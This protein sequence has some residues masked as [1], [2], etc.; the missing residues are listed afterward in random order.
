LAR[1]HLDGEVLISIHVS[2]SLVVPAEGS[3]TRVDTCDTS[4]RTRSKP[5]NAPLSRVVAGLS[6]SRGSDSR[7]CREGPIPRDLDRSRRSD[8]EPA[9]GRERLRATLI[10]RED[11]TFPAKSTESGAWRA[12]TC[13]W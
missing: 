10:V 6:L 4:T 8:H 7:G 3:H 13:G 9:R 1:L 5:A 2:S 12:R 11:D